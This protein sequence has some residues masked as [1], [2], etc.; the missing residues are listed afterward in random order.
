MAIGEICTRDVLYIGRNESAAEAAR[1]MREN[2]VGCLVVI[3]P[4]R[5]GGR[6][7]G[8][9]TDRDIVV[10]VVALGVDAETTPVE[11]LMRPGVASIREDEGIG[12]ALALMR[13]HGVR[14]LP[15]VDAGGVLVGLVAADD[16]LELFAEEMSGLAGML[17]REFR[18]ERSDRPA[19]QAA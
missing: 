17:S 8:M 2:H 4:P 10:G 9:V 13:E 7:A 18:R 3:D 12:R 11:A 1:L 16:L 15:V 5:A 19:R 14:R 6:P